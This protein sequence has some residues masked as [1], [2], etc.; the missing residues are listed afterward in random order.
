MPEWEVLSRDADRP[1]ARIR[2]RLRHEPY[3]RCT[4][5][6]HVRVRQRDVLDGHAVL[7]SGGG[8]PP[9]RGADHRLQCFA[10]G[11]R[12][13][14]ELRVRP[15]QRYT[16]VRHYPNVQRRGQRGD[17]DLREPVV[18]PSFRS[19]SRPERGRA[20]SEQIPATSSGFVE[21]PQPCGNISTDRELVT[22]ASRLEEFSV[23]R[24]LEPACDAGE[25]LRVE[26][27]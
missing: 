27:D 9:A 12:H 5:R 10:I 26:I 6:R 13:D 1:R 11:L 19:T 15:S 8:R 22:L 21:A 25:R 20:R 7:L 16:F 24:V 14:A 4:E 18:A 3:N 23:R 17:G 2:F